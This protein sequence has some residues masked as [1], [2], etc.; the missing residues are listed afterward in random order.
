[1]AALIKTAGRLLPVR[2]REKREGKGVIIHIH[3]GYTKQYSRLFLR[4]QGK[5]RKGGSATARS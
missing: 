2:M 1:M 4:A 3:F 5:K